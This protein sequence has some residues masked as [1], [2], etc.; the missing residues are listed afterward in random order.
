MCLMLLLLAVPSSTFASPVRS[1]GRLRTA[2]PRHDEIDGVGAEKFQKASAE[3]CR[4]QFAMRA[5]LRAHTTKIKQQQLQDAM[6]QKM[7]SSQT[8]TTTRSL[9]LRRIHD[10]DAGTTFV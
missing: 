6:E 7:L 8:T 10:D 9:L 2:V 5:N 4:S 1:E 3:G